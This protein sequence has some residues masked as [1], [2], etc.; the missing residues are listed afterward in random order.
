MFVA[1]SCLTLC[2]PM[3]CNPPGSSVHGILQARMLEW[4]AIPFSRGAFWLLRSLHALYYSV[5]TINLFILPRT[6]QHPIHGLGLGSCI[7][8]L[9]FLG[10]DGFLAGYC[11]PG[12]HSF[13]I[14]GAGGG[15]WPRVPR[16][17]WWQ[18][19]LCLSGEACPSLGQTAAGGPGRGV[20]EAWR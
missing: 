8:W 20:W 11:S 2:E 6:P 14:P 5:L 17:G 10:G 13:S 12:C 7:N 16:P 3:D 1:Q 15:Q 19:R 4:F 9:H 18:L